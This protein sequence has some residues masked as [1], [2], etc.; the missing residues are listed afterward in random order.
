MT[1]TYAHH[2]QA[3]LQLQKLFC[4]FYQYGQDLW[5]P[6]IL[7]LPQE[8]LL[9]NRQAART[10]KVVRGQQMGELFYYRTRR[11]HARLFVGQSYFFFYNK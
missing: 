4:F 7:R 1:Y 2:A 10:I 3:C 11:V 5:Y 9:Q 8:K 6:K